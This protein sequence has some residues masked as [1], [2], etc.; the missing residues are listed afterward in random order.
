M[1]ELAVTAPINW[2]VKMMANVAAMPA[3]AMGIDYDAI[4]EDLMN[5]YSIGPS[6]NLDRLMQPIHEA[7]APTLQEIYQSS[8]DQYGEEQA[9]LMLK[10]LE[11]Y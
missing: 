6:E 9:K 4:R 10:G 5:R 11:N 7:L 3:V 2:S 8:V 1:G